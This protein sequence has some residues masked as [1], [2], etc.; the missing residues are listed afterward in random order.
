MTFSSDSLAGIKQKEL[1][2]KLDIV[3]KL[4][5]EH[6]GIQEAI[7]ELME[8]EGKLQ[9]EVEGETKGNETVVKA[10]DTEVEKLEEALVLSDLY[11][12]D[13]RIQSK[14]AAWVRES[15]IEAPTFCSDGNKVM[16]E[17]EQNIRSSTPYGFH[18][19]INVQLAT[20]ESLLKQVRTKLYSTPATPTT[21][22][23]AEPLKEKSLPKSVLPPP[24]KVQTPTFN[25]K[26]KEF[27]HFLERL[28]SIMDLHSDFYPEADKLS[29]L[30]EAM[31]DQEAK[32][33]VN[34]SY[35]LGYEGALEQLQLT[36]GRKTTIYPQLVEEFLARTKYDYSRESMRLILDRTRRVLNDMEKLEGRNLDIFAVSMV[37]R[38][39][40]QELANRVD[41]TP[42]RRR[43]ASHTR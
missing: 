1:R 40:D 29:L 10:Y 42:R 38:D 20:A 22:R 15:K 19:Y 41:K 9:V 27:N 36:Y 23:P 7:I 13:A 34:S 26:P 11:L 2:S 18:G 39:F 16:Q 35:S 32:K 6:E 12:E 43:Q 28:K 25:G 37:T 33:L 21:V 17:L 5:D 8:A 24:Y 31:L 4:V 3:K 30:S 14:A